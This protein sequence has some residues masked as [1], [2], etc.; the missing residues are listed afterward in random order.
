MFEAIINK[1]CI[2]ED[3][4]LKKYQELIDNDLIKDMRNGK[5]IEG[6]L[7]Q[8]MNPNDA[9]VYAKGVIG[10]KNSINNIPDFIQDYLKVGDYIKK[11]IQ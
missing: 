7:P 5:Y 1:Y 10:V 6:I 11:I 3:S 4:L 2:N 9:I 8:Y